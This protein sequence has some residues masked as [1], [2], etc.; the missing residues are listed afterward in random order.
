MEI[1]KRFAYGEDA[2]HSKRAHSP[3]YD[4][5]SRQ[6]NQRRKSRN[7]DGCTMCNQVVV[8]Y[9]KRDREGDENEEYHKKDNHRR[10]RPKY[11]DL[12]AEEILHRP[13]R[14]HYAY[15]DGK[16]VSNHLMRDC[17]TFLKLQEAMELS[18]GAKLESTTYDRTTIDQGYQVQS[19]TGY[20]QS[21]VYIF[22][23]IQPD[24]KSKKEQK[25]ISRQVNLAISSPPATTEY[26]RWSDQTVGFSK[27]DHP[28]KVPR[29]GHAPM[30]LKA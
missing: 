11:F 5:S 14:I 22:A 26:L 15:L 7:K 21:K 23:M 19:G 4:R 13:C 17:K 18:Q 2:Y 25:S 27:E 30:V 29:P 16:R 1:A 10:D 28:R 8:G 24:P 12:S 6:R 20:P 9:G 3:E